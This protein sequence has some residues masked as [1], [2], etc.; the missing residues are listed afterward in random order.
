MIMRRI[1]R[2][3]DDLVRSR[4]PRRFQADDEDAALARTAI[5]LRAARPGSGAPRDEFVAALHRRLSGELD[6]GSPSQA[7]TGPPGSG[8][9]VFLRTATVAGGA[10]VAGAG[11][12]HAL[13]SPA[14]PGSSRLDPRHGT[15]QT[16]A[17]SAQLPDGAV[18]PFVAGPVIGFVERSGGRLRA[19]SGVCTHQGCKLA[20]AARPARLVC[21]CHGA[22]FTLD[23]AVLS[24]RLSIPLAPLA[25]LEVREAGGVI[26][27]LAPAARPAP[28]AGSLPT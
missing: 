26:Q 5:L 4:R 19:V 7:A 28:P 18:R 15:W 12:D 16:V 21:P 8:R 2:Y 23:G 22:S 14:A 6:A 17:T 9:R 3:V 1:T 10:A 25:H 20:L 11:I 27:V 13:T 24:H